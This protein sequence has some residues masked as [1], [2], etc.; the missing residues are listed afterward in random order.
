MPSR[1]PLA[2]SYSPFLF[3]FPFPFVSS[4]YPLSRYPAILHPKPK[5]RGKHMIWLIWRKS[6][7]TATQRFQRYDSPPV[8][9]PPSSTLHS[10]HD[11]PRTLLSTSQDT[12][13]LICPVLGHCPAV[14]DERATNWIRETLQPLQ[15]PKRSDS[16]T[17]KSP[18]GSNAQT[19]LDRHRIKTTL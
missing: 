5:P 13:L 1:F 10:L 15:R 12:G 16:Q 19:H 8:I 3:P 14:R 6:L 9:H 4:R 7:H 2:H 11:H 17:V 18:N